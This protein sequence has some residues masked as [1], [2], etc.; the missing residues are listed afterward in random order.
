MKLAAAREAIAA[1][2]AAIDDEDLPKGKLETTKDGEQIL[3]FGGMGHHL[4]SGRRN[5]ERYP[6][7]HRDRAVSEALE[8]EALYRYDL[9]HL[10]TER[11][12]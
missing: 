9:K 6:L 4:G 5:G 10:A 11:S 1:I 12:A 3:W 7:M 2:L 8:F